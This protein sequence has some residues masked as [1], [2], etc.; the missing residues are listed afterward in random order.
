MTT[1]GPARR[2]VA[3]TVV[4][5]CLTGCAARSPYGVDPPLREAANRFAVALRDSDQNGLTQMAAGDTTAVTP[6]VAL[7]GGRSTVPLAYS[8]SDR[9]IAEVEFTVNCGSG[10]ATF[11]ERFVYVSG[12]WK[13]DLREGPSPQEPALAASAPPSHFPTPTP[14]P[15]C[16]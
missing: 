2:A 4:A 14:Q 6:L 9:G 1:A 13:P 16:G 11:W 10:T 7:R 12:T 8:S 3:A 15:A 5:L